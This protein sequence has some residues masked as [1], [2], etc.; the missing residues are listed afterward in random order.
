AS[1]STLHLEDFVGCKVF[2]LN[3]F[4]LS[5][6]RAVHDQLTETGITPDQRLTPSN[7]MAALA[8]ASAGAGVTF[9]P[10]WVGGIASS[11]VVVRPV[12]DLRHELTL[13]IG[14]RADNPAPGIMPFIDLAELVSRTP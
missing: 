11:D 3:R 2:T 10:A 13:G 14:W 6:F 8:L 9:L 4:D 7:T 1:R 12:G 5:V